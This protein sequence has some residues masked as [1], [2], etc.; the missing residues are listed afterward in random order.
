MSKPKD[1]RAE[2]EQIADMSVGES[3]RYSKKMQRE[4]EK[5]EKKAEEAMRQMSPLQRYR[6][7]RTFVLSKTLYI[8]ASMS[9]MKTAEA[10]EQLRSELRA[11]QVHLLE[12]RA[13]LY[14]V[15]P[16]GHA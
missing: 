11:E 12:L 4:I 13:T 9:V 16:I 10:Q 2:M 6:F 5:L 7:L 14:N 15:G 3:K 1:K 8:R